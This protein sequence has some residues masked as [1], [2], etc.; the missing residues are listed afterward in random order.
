MKCFSFIIVFVCIA[1]MSNAELLV[2]DD[3]DGT[4][5]G[6]TVGW[7]GPPVESVQDGE[8]LRYP[9][10]MVGGTYDTHQLSISGDLGQE[11]CVTTVDDMFRSI[12]DLKEG[13]NVLSISDRSGITKLKLI[14]KPPTWDKYRI[15][16]WYAVPKGE[17][18]YTFTEYGNN[19]DY[20]QI[21]PFSTS[22]ER[23]M[24]EFKEKISTQVKLMQS[25]SAEDMKRAG[26]GRMTV[27]P[28]YDEN[29]DVDVGILELSKTR[30]E[31]IDSGQGVWGLISQAIPAEYKNGYYKN[32]CFTSVR[33]AAL[34][35]GDM[36]MVGTK[37][38]IQHAPTNVPALYD[39]L[40]DNTRVDH[41][42]YR[43]YVGVTVHEMGHQ[44]HSA[45][46]P[47][48]P[49]HVMN[50]HYDVSRQFTL[51][52][53][54][55]NPE[56]HRDRDMGTWGTQQQ[57]MRF[58]RWFMSPDEVAYQDG[59]ISIDFNATNIVCTS[60]YDLAVI[61]HYNPSL[62]PCNYTVVESLNTNTYNLNIE[63]TK[64]AL[65]PNASNQG[66]F[67]IMAVDKE[68]NMRYRGYEID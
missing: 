23:V 10:V 4:G 40:L 32:L 18:P 31:I 49:L 68:G 45:W 11:L 37:T 35:G 19:G 14:Y 63:Q 27:Y 26:L 24:S 39:Y 41:L 30:S 61:Y 54:P 52:T 58:N 60:P 51:Y 38:I 55:N 66:F 3:F 7:A 42:T 48:E 65:E 20:T 22:V 17:D 53:D 64:A 9:L 50:G 62:G 13:T 6:G 28:I 34:G 2:F 33:A 15:K 47:G 21:T 46:H 16:V 29:G 5:G 12:V 25:W 43:D 1:M 57:L 59:T 44:M 67:N 36:C 56:W 8:V